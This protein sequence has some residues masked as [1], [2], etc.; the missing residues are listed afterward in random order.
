MLFKREVEDKGTF[1][2]WSLE[3]LGGVWSLGA[4]IYIYIKYFWHKLN[5]IARRKPKYNQHGRINAT[6]VKIKICKIISQLQTKLSRMPI[7]N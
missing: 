6:R 4:F 1:I 7:L 5:S 3:K 2:V